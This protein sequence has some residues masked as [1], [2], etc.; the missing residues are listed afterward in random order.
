MTA[1]YLA[2]GDSYTIGEGVAPDD[3]WPVQLVSALHARGISIEAPV[4]IAQTGWTTEELLATLEIGRA[5]V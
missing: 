5:H 4:I 1:S 2:L 3:R